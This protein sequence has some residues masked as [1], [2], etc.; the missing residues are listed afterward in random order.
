MG[1]EAPVSG[2]TIERQG[3]WMLNEYDPGN[4]QCHV[5]FATYIDIRD[6]WH[7]LTVSVSK[8]ERA[9]SGQSSMN[10]EILD[11]AAR[12]PHDASDII[13]DILR[14]M[15]RDSVLK[16]TPRFV[17]IDTDSI[18]FE[19]HNEE[20]G[21]IPRLTNALRSLWRV[22]VTREVELLQHLGERKY[23]VRSEDQIY[24][25][26]QVPNVGLMEH[27]FNTL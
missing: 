26:Y 23:R 24:I 7:R 15:L 18:L 14:G 5:F 19:Q 17:H 10:A 20:A 13:D 1:E 22:P 27:F 12:S 2:T 3:K 4:E 9:D 8:P 25:F 21:R 6:K 16:D 11:T